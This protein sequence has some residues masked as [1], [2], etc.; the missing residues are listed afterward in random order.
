MARALLVLMV[1]GSVG[2][3]VSWQPLHPQPALRSDHRELEQFVE[4]VARCTPT[5]ALIFFILPSEDSDGGFANYCLRYLL[6]GRYVA[7]NLDKFSPPL[8]HVDYIAV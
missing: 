4:D 1:L 5:H 6:G 3:A 8:P 2:W 7:T